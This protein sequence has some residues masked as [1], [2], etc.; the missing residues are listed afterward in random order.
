MS[1]DL[2]G[3]SI[4]RRGQRNGDMGEIRQ[5][6]GKEGQEGRKREDQVLA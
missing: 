5:Q 4:Y 3:D 6:Q 2:F 1:F